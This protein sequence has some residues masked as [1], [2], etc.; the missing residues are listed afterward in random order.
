M[1]YLSLN[2]QCTTFVEL[3]IL[4]F[5]ALIAIANAIFLYATLR[6]QTKQN[7]DSIFY[8]LVESHK[9]LTDAMIISACWLNDDA[10]EERV[11]MIGRHFFEYA[12]SELSKIEKSLCTEKYKSPS[13]YDDISI[14]LEANK[15]GLQPNK[16]YGTL[17]EESKIGYINHLYKISEEDW[18]QCHKEKDVSVSAYKLF[19]RQW[20]GVYERY[21]RSL[22]L[23]LKYI[24]E[25]RD[26]VY[27]E[28]LKVQLSL[29]ELR[30]IKR[31][32]FIDKELNNILLKINNKT[33]QL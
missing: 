19:K 23:I 9:K 30:I 1:C 20:Y 33:S 18:E 12:E 22:N 7:I 29:N 3:R 28:Y 11:T 8:K 6:A 27:L 17:L 31:H 2:P 5:T 16:S 10:T 32:S 4:S 26:E 24:E 15:S 13:C 21:F 25:N 14:G